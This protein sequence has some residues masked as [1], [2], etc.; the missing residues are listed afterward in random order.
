MSSKQQ[1]PI[2]MSLLTDDFDIF[3]VTPDPNKLLAAAPRITDK[4]VLPIIKMFKYANWF[5]IIMNLIAIVV[6]LGDGVLYPIIAILIGDVFDSDVFNPLALDVQG[7]QDICNDTAKKF[8]YIGVGLFFTS[9]IR[10]FIF[11]ITGNNQIRRIRRLYITS[12]LS[13]EMGWYDANN[14][15]EMTSKMTGDIFLLHDAIG[16]KVGEFFSYFGMCLTG[17]IIGFVKDWKLCF[18]MISVAP[19]MAGS[20][21][22]FAFVQSKSASSTQ[23]S[24]AVAGGIAS[25]TISNMRTVAAIGIEKSRIH[26][27]LHTLRH[28]LH[29]GIKAAHATG[30]STGYCFSLFSLL[31]GLIQNQELS[32][33]QLAIVVFAVLCGTLGLSQIATPIGAIFKGK[34][35]A[36]RIFKTIKRQPKIINNGKRHISEI[37]TGDITFEG[38]SF[39]Y[40]T[41]PDILI[42]NNFNLEIKAGHSVGLVGPSGCGKSTIV[43]LL[44]RLYEPVD[45]KIMIDGI[46]IKEFDL[47]E[48][49]SMFGVVGQEPSLFAISIKEN[50]ALG[51]NRDLIV[52]RLKEFKDPQDIL[53]SNSL[54]EDVM[55]CAQMANATTFI[56]ALPHG[57]DTVLG[58]RGAQISGG[59]K[60]R[61]SIARALMN[62]PK[63]LILDEA[64]SALDFK[65]E[66]NCS[67]CP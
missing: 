31:F 61:I 60:Q 19:F 21:G 23:A 2:E 22:I 45:G 43:G 62:N 63:L 66:K 29:V 24:Y 16:P 15:G 55:R 8:A 28:S 40:P 36:Y 9:A 4:G 59:Q 64:T 52:S 65:S 10:N 27:Y 49:R 39:C 38:V 25:E 14:T 33:G 46:D 11:E 30:G 3:D 37:K 7:M 67:T 34:A 20:A 53:R 6:S 26:Q 41:R 5:E 35:A 32:A 50:I 18:V 58:Q 48:Y 1:Q 54:E 57:F 44:Q 51:A 17:Y 12:L 42:L 56:R 47:Y 13:Q